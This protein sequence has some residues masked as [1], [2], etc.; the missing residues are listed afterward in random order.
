MDRVCPSQSEDS[1][2][3]RDRIVIAQSDSP[4]P[5][6]A[7]RLNGESS[8]NHSCRYCGQ[9]APDVRLTVDHVVPKALGGT[10]APSNLVAACIDCNVGKASSSPDAALVSSG[11]L[12]AAA[13]SPP[14]SRAAMPGAPAGSDRV[15]GKR[16]ALPRWR[17]QS[18]T[19]P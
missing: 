17:A 4:E 14:P 5:I 6:L 9:C 16:Y 2:G 10:D 11:R 3:C 1:G 7:G 8:D 19:G 15:A 13:G 12:R 18:W